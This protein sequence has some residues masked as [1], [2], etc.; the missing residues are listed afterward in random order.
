MTTNKDDGE[1]LKVIS[2]RIDK[3]E[4]AFEELKDAIVEIRDATKKIAS[5][6]ETK[7]T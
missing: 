1:N 6:E 3:M 5:L 2:Y 7:V 4:Q